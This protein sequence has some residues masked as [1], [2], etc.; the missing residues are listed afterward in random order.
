MHIYKFK[1][2]ASQCPTH[3]SPV[4]NGEVLDIVM[5]KNAWMSEVTGFGI[6]QSHHQPIVFHLLDHI[7]TRNLLEPVDKFID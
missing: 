4:G 5:H 7:T 1:I 3:Y 6:L 2:L